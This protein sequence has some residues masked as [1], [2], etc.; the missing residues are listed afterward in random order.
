MKKLTLLSLLAALVVALTA[1]PH[2]NAAE[3]EGIR[4][5]KALSSAYAEIAAKVSPSVVTIETEKRLHD[6]DGAEMSIPPNLPPQFR[7]FFE[8]QRRR[9]RSYQRAQ[10]MGSGFI[11]DKNG[12]I[13][14]NS[15]VVHGASK[16]KV[17]LQDDSE[18]SAKVIGTDP[19]TDI[20]VIK[21]LD[22]SPDKIVPLPLGDSD[23]VKVGNLVIAIGA[24]FGLKQTVT[25]GIVSATNRD[26]L[27][28]GELRSVMYQDFIQTD[29]TINPGN[30]GGPLVNLDGEVVGINS[31]ISTASGGSDGVGFSISI[32]MAKTV[33]TELLKSGK[34]TRGYLGVGIRDITP[35]MHKLMPDLKGGAIVLQI[36]PNT[37]ATE[38]G[39]QS[40]DI[41]VAY[42]GT[43][44]ESSSHLQRLVARTPVGTKVKIDILR[45][46]E[47]QT[48]HVT[49]RKQ[50]KK[51]GDEEANEDE[52]EEETAEEADSAAKYRSEMLGLE[53]VPLSEAGAEEN[54][55][56]ADAKGLLVT[57]VVADSVA[58]RA[59][60]ERGALIILINQKPVTTIEEFKKVEES[61]KGKKGALLLFRFGKL[62]NVATLDLSEQKPDK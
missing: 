32:N 55:A 42:N 47:P 27:G 16:I 37:P 25:C 14:T 45:H 43:P 58:D 30:S 26:R 50:P 57:G 3:S 41:L 38:G 20:A 62:N 52:D 31:A 8:Q 7:R 61:L 35:E 15:H 54:K 24:P 34:V 49:I 46:G 6:E 29:A 59:G 13:L 48:L 17:I 36:Y 21:L 60:L 51:M 9:P 19:K 33:M 2:G 22:A 11:V 10:G 23:T 39:M 28:S 44:L 56:Y 4:V 5:A 1:A 40:G 53:V 18:Y 12:T